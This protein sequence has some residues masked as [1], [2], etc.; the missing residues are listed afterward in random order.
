[1]SNLPPERRVAQLN[2]DEALRRIV[3]ART[4]LIIGSAGVTAGIAVFVADTAPGKTYKAAS[5]TPVVRAAALPPLASP[6]ALGLHPARQASPSNSSTQSQTSTASQPPTA[7]QT[8]PA[9]TA[10]Q[11]AVTATQPTATAPPVST[12]AAPAPVVSGG[13]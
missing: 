8:Q 3:R 12:S 2:R 9:V 4:G 7:T 5:K 11:P 1:M 6:R 10:T 13:S